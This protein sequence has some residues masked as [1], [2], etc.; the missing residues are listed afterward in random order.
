MSQAPVQDHARTSERTTPLKDL[1]KIKQGTRIS[2]ESE[3]DLAI[4][5]KRGRYQ[6]L[7]ETAERISSGPL[8]EKLAVEMHMDISHDPFHERIHRNNAASQTVYPDLILALTPAS[9]IRIPQC[10]GTNW[11]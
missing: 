5:N 11:L 4:R 6:D 8:C 10:V 9:S 7:Y 2:A 1:C 3:H